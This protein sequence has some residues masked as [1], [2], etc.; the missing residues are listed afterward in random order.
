MPSSP[1]GPRRAASQGV[2]GTRLRHCTAQEP[3]AVAMTGSGRKLKKVRWD[4]SCLE[5]RAPLRLE[6]SVAAPASHPAVLWPG[7][8]S[9]L[10]IQLCFPTA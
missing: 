7:V 6:A 3:D 8:T 1:S 5:Q 10:F 2:T 9:L 4:V